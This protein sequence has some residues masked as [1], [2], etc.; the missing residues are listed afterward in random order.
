MTLISYRHN[1]M[2]ET[3]IRHV[4]GCSVTM[5]ENR[6]HSILLPITVMAKIDK[7]HVKIC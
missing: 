2:T 5:T 6:L 3:S 1:S 4:K 7:N